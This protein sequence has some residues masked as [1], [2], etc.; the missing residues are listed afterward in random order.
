MV[1]TDREDRSMVIEPTQ[2]EVQ[3]SRHFEE[4]RNQIARCLDQELGLKAE[5]RRDRARQL[6]IDL[7]I[8][9]HDLRSAR[10]SSAC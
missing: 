10:Q 4:V 8:S 3:R 7:K 5:E 6:G 2:L 1:E 9:P